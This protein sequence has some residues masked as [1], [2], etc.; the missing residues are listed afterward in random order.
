MAP[1]EMNT[2]LKPKIKPMEFHIVLLSSRPSGSFNSSAE[3][4]EMSDT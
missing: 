4:P 2:I 1:K 3:T